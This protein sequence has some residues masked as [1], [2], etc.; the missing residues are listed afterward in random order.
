[1][2][3][4]FTANDGNPQSIVEAGVDG[5]TVGAI[6]CGGLGSTYCSPAVPH[7]TGLP[8]T[9][10]AEGSEVATDNDVTLIAE[11]LPPSQFGRFVTALNQG[12]TPNLGGGLGTLCRGAGLAR[13]SDALALSDFNGSL[14]YALD[15]T[16]TPQGAGFVT[17]MAGEPWNYQAWFRA[18]TGGGSPTSNLTDGVSV[19]YQ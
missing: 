12:F 6:D 5:F 15:L 18:L 11:Q 8:A 9:I 16:L 1:M 4:R 10:R 17:V 3:V 14:S 13:Y 2:R 7:L 19:T